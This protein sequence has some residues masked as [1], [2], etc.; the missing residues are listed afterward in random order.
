MRL[1]FMSMYGLDSSMAAGLV[2]A[3][4]AL[5]LSER[6]SSSAKSALDEPVDDSK[7][8]WSLWRKIG[9]KWGSLARHSFFSSRVANSETV[10]T[11]PSKSVS[12]NEENMGANG[13]GSGNF[14]AALL[15]QSAILWPERTTLFGL[16]LL[17]L[18]SLSKFE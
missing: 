9:K 12:F 1:R 2:L 4:R 10:V 14:Q 16:R 5:R 15:F 11:P 3:R 6:L 7:H 18:P 17:G 8:V 13:K